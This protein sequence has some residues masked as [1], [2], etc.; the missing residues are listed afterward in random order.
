MFVCVMRAWY[1]Q[2]PEEGIVTLGTG[3]RNGFELPR[4]CRKLNLGPLEEKPVLLT[5]KPSAA[6]LFVF[7]TSAFQSIVTKTVLRDK[8]I[9]FFYDELKTN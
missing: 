2:R 9:S 1:P 3:V 4:E 8:M 6:P 5:A 7:Q